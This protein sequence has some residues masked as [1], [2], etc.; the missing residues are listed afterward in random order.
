MLKDVFNQFFL[1]NLDLALIFFC[2]FERHISN[3]KENMQSN[4]KERQDQSLLLECVLGQ[5]S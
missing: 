1:K 5:K 2:H 4:N 3:K